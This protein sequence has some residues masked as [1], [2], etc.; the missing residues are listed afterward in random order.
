MTII[1]LKA[2]AVVHKNADQVQ[3][4]GF[5]SGLWIDIYGCNWMAGLSHWENLSGRIKL[6]QINLDP[7]DKETPDRSLFSTTP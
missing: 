2:D 3:T 7:G 1:L 4:P 6:S 5:I